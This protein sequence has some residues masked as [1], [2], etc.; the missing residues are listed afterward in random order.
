MCT[1]SPML[2]MNF[3]GDTDGKKFACNAGDLDLIPGSGRSSGGGHHNLLQ[4]SCPDN[5]K[6][7]KPG[8]LQSIVLHRVGHD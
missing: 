5:L 1:K 4:Y 8:G 6:T 2:S 7:E 3:L